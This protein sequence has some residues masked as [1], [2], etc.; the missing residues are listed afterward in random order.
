MINS[1][2]SI[3]SVPEPAQ[4]RMAPVS[5]HVLLAEDGEDNRRLFTHHLTRAGI[6]VTCVENGQKAVHAALAPDSS[7]DLILMDMQMPVMDGYSAA[8][9]LRNNG[10]TGRIVALTA[11]AM[12]G[13]R[14][15][16]LDAGCD[17]YLTKPVDAEKLI[18]TVRGAT[19]ARPA[20][21]RSTL[22]EQSD[23]DGP[24]FSLYADDEDMAEILAEFVDG[25]P[26]KLDALEKAAS[27]SDMAQV[28]ARAHDLKGSGGGFG[29][30]AISK[31]AETVEYFARDEESNVDD[32]ATI[33]SELKSV[34][35]RAVVGPPA[36]SASTE[37]ADESVPADQS[38]QSFEPARENSHDV[39]AR[40]EELASTDPEWMEVSDVLQNLT[41]ILRQTSV[42]END[43]SPDDVHCDVNANE[44]AVG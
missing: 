5:A 35:E 10:Y 20:A 13:D 25:L 15:R 8:D 24:I 23:V 36:T 16:C 40:I 28:A 1:P 44:S 14:E 27:E 9:E 37:R 41:T 2:D 12:S 22:V 18:E 21:C 33:L 3:K 38:E 32:C 7:F 4:P 39:L 6:Q 26:G 30:P 34:C 43:S 31:A 29:F 17:D 11:H 19:D 42:N